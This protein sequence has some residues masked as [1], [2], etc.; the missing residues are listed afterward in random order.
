MPRGLALLLALLLVLPALAEGQQ[1]RRMLTED[2][3][4]DWTA[5]GRLNIAG[6][7]FC[8]GTLIEPDLVLTAAHCL[9][10]PRSRRLVS[11]DRI[12]FL[13]GWRMG[14]AKAHRRVRRIMIDSGYRFGAPRDRDHIEKDI[15]VLELESPIPLDIAIPF[16]RVRRPEA[17]QSLAVVSYARD[18]SEA[19]SIEEPCRALSI[20]GGT[21]VMNCDVTFGA[22]G[23]P[24][25]AM[26]QGR[27]RIASVVSA[28]GTW[29]GER[30]SLGMA[31]DDGRLQGVLNDVTSGAARIEIRRPGGS[32]A[33][34]LGR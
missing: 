2:E 22:S 15:A 28:M 29:Q 13:A 26:G 21:I 4:K 20:D 5:V 32:I 19:P 18:R 23:S 24:V 17:G 14:E 1:G 34:Q 7:G 8:T 11:A 27:P 10:H 6:A 12:H 9:Y 31:L 25:F 33:D 16:G 30:V 3:A